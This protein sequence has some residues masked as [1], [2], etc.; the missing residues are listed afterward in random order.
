MYTSNV[1]APSSLRIAKPRS[2]VARVIP[3]SYLEYQRRIA[4]ARK[5][6]FRLKE[7]EELEQA[8]E[9]QGEVKTTEASTDLVQ[10]QLSK[11]A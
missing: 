10:K 4:M 5:D 7:Q 1:V 2:Q 3:E 6:Y 8:E 9:G 11:L